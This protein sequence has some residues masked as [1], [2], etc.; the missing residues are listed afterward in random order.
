MFCCF[1]PLMFNMQ[2]FNRTFKMYL[3]ERLLHFSASVKSKGVWMCGRLCISFLH[4]LCPLA[5][6]FLEGVDGLQ[7]FPLL[8]P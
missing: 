1:T 8:W 3:L 5:S 7:C 6:L 4:N 2:T